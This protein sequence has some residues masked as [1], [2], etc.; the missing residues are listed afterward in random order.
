VIASG[1]DVARLR[2]IEIEADHILDRRA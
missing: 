2:G 1:S